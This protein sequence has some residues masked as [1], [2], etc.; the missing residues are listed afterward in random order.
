MTALVHVPRPF[1][2]PVALYTDRA[3]WAFHTP[4]AGGP[5]DRAPSLTS[6]ASSHSAGSGTSAPIP[7]KARGRGERLNRTLQDRLVNELRLA[8]VT[9]LEA[10]NAYLREH[11]IP[12]GGGA[13]GEPEVRTD[14]ARSCDMPSASILTSCSR[15]P[16]PTTGARKLAS[17]ARCS[18]PAATR[19]LCSS[20]MAQ[21]CDGPWRC[22]SARASTSSRLHWSARWISEDRRAIGSASCAA[23]R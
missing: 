17:F 10:A 9:T 11:F 23:S 4:K 18:S 21:A 19:R 16:A 7:P 5:V 1:G 22:S 3:G 13:K 14:L 15:A 12:D 6:A 8:G 20:P 2:L